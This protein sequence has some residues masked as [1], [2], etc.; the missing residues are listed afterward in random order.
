MS[1]GTQPCVRVAHDYLTQRGGAERVALKIAEGLGDGPLLTAI[2]NPEG[3]YSEFRDLRIDSTPLSWFAFF[4]SDPRRALPLLPL[5]WALRA[6]V[7]AD[8]VVCSSS[9][10][11]HGVRTDDRTV[12]V[13]YCHNPPRW[14]YQPD[15]YF[16]GQPRAV[17][18]AAALLRP[19]LLAWDRRA[20]ASVTTYV[21][22]STAV[23]DR[24]RQAYGVSAKV[25]HPPIGL[26]AEGSQ[27]ALPLAP[28]FF[29]TVAR[30]RGY[31]GTSRLV[32]AWEGLPGSRLV[33]VGSWSQRT[34][35]N[36]TSV[37]RVSDA[38]LRWLYAN[39]CGLVSVS[40]EDFGLTP[41]EANAFG[42]PSLVIRAGGFLDST[43]EGVSG[44]FIEEDTVE[45]IRTAVAG[46]PMQWDT[47][48]IRK[49]AD[50][51]SN[52]S[53]LHALRAVVTDSIRSKSAESN[54]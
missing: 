26:D 18:V 37:G 11:S 42:T 14:L 4:R 8:A 28:G 5:A 19:L 49:H 41:L 2:Y 36:V 54:P 52:S 9:G 45:G 44:M 15:D 24:V 31:K 12:K 46:F 27:S 38:Q 30:E 51:F 7:K 53:F 43:A 10:W 33:I 16:E 50:G 48:A 40:H 22:N 39:A 23:A 6:P 3:T 1:V 47:K 29:L 21:A 17:R 20:A 34:P 13:V 35:P 32:E 25:I